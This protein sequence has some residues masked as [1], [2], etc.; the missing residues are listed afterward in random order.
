MELFPDN[1]S[2]TLLEFTEERIEQAPN[3]YGVFIL[4]KSDEVIYIGWGVPTVRGE[5]RG[6][7]KTKFG[8]CVAKATHFQCKQS[9]DYLNEYNRLID[10]YKAHRCALPPCNENQ[11]ADLLHLEP[12]DKEDDG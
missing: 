1:L 7:L 3:R 5:L 12:L 11:N 8:P 2:D 4:Y 6:A 9:S 10:E